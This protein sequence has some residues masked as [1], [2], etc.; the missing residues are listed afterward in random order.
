M[1][2]QMNL[3][4]SETSSPSHR[5]QS[6]SALILTS[7][8]A[9]SF[10][11]HL[12]MDVD[13]ISGTEQFTASLRHQQQT[14]EVAQ[15]RHGTRLGNMKPLSLL[16]HEFMIVQTGQQL[17][18]SLNHRN[19]IRQSWVA[20]LYA[21]SVEPLKTLKKLHIKDL[22]LETHHRG[23]YI[24]LRV[25]TPPNTMTAVMVIAEDEHGNGIMHMVYQ[26]EDAEY[27]L[28][29]DIVQVGGVCIVK[30]PYFK[31]MSNGDYG[32]RVD[33]VTDI[34]WLAKDDEMVPFRWGPRNTRF[35][36]TAMEL[37]VTGNAALKARDLNKAVEW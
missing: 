33:H 14:L 31:T 3:L 27:W 30:E 10:L 35:E 32:V 13:N 12:N 20:A 4:H 2:S 22:R 29:G 26:Q 23:N 24:I 15:R 21:P 28:A 6:S 34:V 18:H 8:A 25:A 37:K 16:I 11:N 5:Y 36:E 7:S 17:M 1:I 9:S 19:E